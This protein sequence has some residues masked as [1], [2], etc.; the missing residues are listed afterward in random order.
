VCATVCSV[1]LTSS[2]RSIDHRTPG[3][4]DAFSSW[5]ASYPAQHLARVLSAAHQDDP[6]DLIG[7]VT[8]RED[9]GAGRGDVCTVPRSCTPGTPLAAVTTTASTSAAD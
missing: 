1:L 3:S 4:L 6:L 8:D 9:A 2:V 7:L 5:T